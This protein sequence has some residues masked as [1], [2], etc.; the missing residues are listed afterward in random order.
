MNNGKSTRKTNRPNNN[1]KSRNNGKPNN[2]AKRNSRRTKRSKKNG[3]SGSN[4]V[5]STD[6][7]IHSLAKS[8]G[9]MVLTTSAA[10]AYSCCRMYG[11]IPRSP[12]SIP[13][14]CSGKH[15]AVCLY[16]IDRVSPGSAGQ[17]LYIQQNGWLPAPLY[18]SSPAATAFSVNGIACSVARVPL[19]ISPEYSIGIPNSTPGNTLDALDVYRASGVRIVS[20]TVI[21]KYTGPVNTCAGMIRAF[22]NHISVSDPIMTTGT[23]ATTTAP[24]TGIGFA[25]TN[26][27]ATNT[28]FANSGTGI[29]QLDGSFNPVP[30]PDNFSCRPEKGMVVRMKHRSSTFAQR[31]IY[32]TPLG[33]YAGSATIS[34]A[35]GFAT[36]AVCEIGQYGGGFIS[37][38][39]NWVGNAIALENLNA[40]ASYTIETMVCVEFTPQANSAFVK[41]TKAGPPANRKIIDNVEQQLNNQGVGLSM[42]RM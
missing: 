29:C 36:N 10:D 39:N 9:Q 17:T 19:G 5:R 21:I 40:D 13:D 27:A 8:T 25:G 23:S 22:E 2:S 35:T 11:I 1:N 33:F 30:P 14:G 3:G 32:P 18:I 37:Y 28:R 31:P 42:D 41:L 4:P 12:P 20:N 16:N 15:M 24:T 38:D 6:S 7:I 34:A 26:T